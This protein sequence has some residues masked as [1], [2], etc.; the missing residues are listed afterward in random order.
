MKD[1][2]IEES[3]DGKC[4]KISDENMSMKM[5]KEFVQDFATQITKVANQIGVPLDEFYEIQYLLDEMKTV[6]QE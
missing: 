5:D 4:V 1:I 2:T 6:A 3:D